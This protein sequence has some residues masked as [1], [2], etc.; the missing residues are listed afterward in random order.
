MGAQWI[1]ALT[2]GRALFLDVSVSLVRVCVLLMKA[3]RRRLPKDGIRSPRLALVPVVCLALSKGVWRCVSDG[4][5]RIELVVVF[6]GSARIQSTFVCLLGGSFQSTLLFISGGCCS[7]A[8]VSWGRSMTTSQPSTTINFARL[9]R[10]RGD[11][12]GLPLARFHACSCH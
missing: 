7:G 5:R 11:D 12:G 4:S 1:L 9:R 6:A 2:C 8:L 10:G 3:R